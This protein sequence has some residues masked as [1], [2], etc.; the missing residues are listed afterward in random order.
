MADEGA[1]IIDIGGQSTRP[2]AERLS[3]EVKFSFFCSL[4]VQGFDY[5]VQVPLAT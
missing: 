3:T 2:G 1:D 4:G 5:E